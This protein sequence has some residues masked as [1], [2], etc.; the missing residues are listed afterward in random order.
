[1][2]GYLKMS[3]LLP[4][5]HRGYGVDHWMIWK[6]LDSLS[7]SD[8]CTSSGCGIGLQVGLEFQYYV[9]LLDVYTCMAWILVCWIWGVYRFSLKNLWW[10]SST[11]IHYSGFSCLV[12]YSDFESSRWEVGV[13]VHGCFLNTMFLHVLHAEIKACSVL[14]IYWRAIFWTLVP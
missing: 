10:C 14:W 6:L 2:H 8:A 5:M 7:L 3:H 12:F 13:D 11:I 1:M 9:F 4:R